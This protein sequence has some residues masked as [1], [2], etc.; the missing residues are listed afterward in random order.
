[1]FRSQSSN[2]LSTSTWLHM[3]TQRTM[4]AIHFLS[5]T[6]FRNGSESAE[7]YKSNKESQVS[8][9]YRLESSITFTC[10]TYVKTLFRQ[11]FFR[12]AMI[13]CCLQHY[14]CT[15]SR[16]IQVL[17]KVCTLYCSLLNSEV[18]L[19]SFFSHVPHCRG[20]SACCQPHFV[21]EKYRTAHLNFLLFKMKFTSE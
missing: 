2:V 6:F 19:L 1:M 14:I 11:K 8:S 4:G 16:R 21:Y 17:I 12:D 9:E 10:L 13:C 7:S 15:L 18:W 5:I 20:T 3:R